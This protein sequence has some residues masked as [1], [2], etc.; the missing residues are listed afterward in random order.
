MLKVARGL[1]PG[2]ADFDAPFMWAG[3]R[4]MTPKGTPILGQAKHRNLWF[5]TGLGHMGWTMSHGSARV[6]A[7]LIAGRKPDLDLRGMTLADA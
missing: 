2:G 4:P 1:F 3:L 5:N 6:T 7:D